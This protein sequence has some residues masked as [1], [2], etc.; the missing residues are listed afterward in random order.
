MRTS[1]L[2]FDNIVVAGPLPLVN[3]F[4]DSALRAYARLEV[5]VFGRSHTAYGAFTVVTLGI[6]GVY[7]N[8]LVLVFFVSAHRAC[9][10]GAFPVV[11]AYRS[12]AAN[13]TFYAMVVFADV[14]VKDPL[15]VVL[16]CTAFET[17][18]AAVFKSVLTRT[19]H[20][21]AFANCVMVI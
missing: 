15:M 21:T 6:A 7:Y 4:L 19:K 2:V 16:G 5:V 18:R 1:H 20:Y 8:P 11:I 12:F 3:V 10:V 14:T 13:R 9:T 17:G